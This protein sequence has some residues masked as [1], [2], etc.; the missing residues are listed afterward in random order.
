MAHRTPSE[1]LLALAR[2]APADR[3]ATLLRATTALFCQEPAHDRDG[4][5]RYEQLATYFLPKASE[6]D[7]A[8]VASMLAGR[9]DAPAAVMRL[10]ARDVIS[11]AAPV[12]RQSPVLS[13]VDLLGVIAVT[14]AEHHRLVAM[15]P[16]LSPEV[17]RALEI[18]GESLRVAAEPEPA[19]PEPEERYEDD[20]GIAWS[21]PLRPP[22]PMEP[23]APERNLGVSPNVMARFLDLPTTARLQ[24]IGEVAGRQGGGR[25]PGSPAGQ[26]DQAV[27]SAYARA[28]IVICS[29]R[30]DRAGLVQA[31]AEVLQVDPELVDRLIADPSGEPLVLMVK[32]SGLSDADGRS[33]LLLA[34]PQI[35]QSV[36]RF[37]RLAELF[38]S[39]EPA[40]ASSFVDAWRAPASRPQHAP[41]YAD[42]RERPVRAQ[43]R[44]A[45]AVQP[46]TRWRTG[47]E[48]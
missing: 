18:A 10:L 19:A 16:H 35:G 30:G 8:Y 29:R 21:P 36:E 11:V 4:V 48:G 1:D 43:E 27:R 25:P 41:V 46:E 44:S 47:S 42:G 37:F 2:S 5:R 32:A 6:P 14:G 40:V 13:T 26:L 33:V 12:L 15:R 22:H 23:P 7:R 38:A 31:F 34:N 17:L 24:V 20:D 9:A 28:Q 45:P 39:V 3:D